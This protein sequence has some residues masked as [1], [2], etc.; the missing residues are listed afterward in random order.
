MSQ[1]IPTE[2]GGTPSTPSTSQTVPKFQAKRQINFGSHSPAH[3]DP[4][5]PEYQDTICQELISLIPSVVSSLQN[6]KH[7]DIF[8]KYTRLLSDG[9]LP[10]E[11]IAHLLFENLVQFFSQ[12]ETTTTMCYSTDVKK[13]WNIGLK[14]FRGKLVALNTGDELWGAL[15][16]KYIP[17]TAK[18]NF[19]VP[20]RDVLDKTPYW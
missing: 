19:I 20:S 18:V 7:L 1:S 5:I 9:A 8:L 4:Q 17:S 13:V 2:N 15:R 6:T 11:N 10:L 16:T 3:R 12:T 14:I